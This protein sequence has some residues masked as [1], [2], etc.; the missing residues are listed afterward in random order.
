M[1][2]FKG[3]K[4]TEETKR[5][6]SKNNGRYW[7]GKHHIEKTKKKISESVK[8]NP[9]KYW[10]GKKHLEETKKKIS[11]SKKGKVGNFKNH[12][13]SETTK[14]K[15]CEARIKYYRN[16][17]NPFKNT[18]IELIMKK[19]LKNKDIKFTQQY[20][21]GNHLV[22]FFIEPNIVIECDGIYWHNLIRVKKRDS[23]LNKMMFEKGYKVYRFYGNKIKENINK[24]L[25]SIGELNNDY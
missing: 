16:R 13:H 22:D 23:V 10:K 3:Y 24:C 11:N 6:I 7:F 4:H 25:N 14:S 12:K 15:M 17:L 21:I 5:K 20:R 1:G 9:T 8:K 19:A 18:D 2:R